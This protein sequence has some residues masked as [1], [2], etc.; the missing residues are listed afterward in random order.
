MKDT[1]VK[2]I[3]DIDMVKL[4]KRIA[5]VRIL[6]GV[7][8]AIDAAFKFEPSIYNN[9]LTISQVADSGEPSWLNPWFNFWFWLM[10]SNQLLIGILVIIIEVAIAVSLL[11][12]LARRLN[13]ALAAVFSFL[14][15]AVGEGFG[16]PYVAGKT[17]INAAIIYVI[18]FILLYVVDGVIPPSWS[19]DSLLTK[20]ISWWH[21]ISDR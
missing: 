2:K 12:G 7:I 11:V 3:S 4:S 14:I 8:W 6:F 20:R 15:W 10:S 17:D 19:L 5:I 21:K 16:G 18:V 1:I 13:Y 9:I